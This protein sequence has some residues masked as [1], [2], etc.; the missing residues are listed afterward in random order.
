MMGSDSG[1]GPRFTELGPFLLLR[2]IGEGGMGAIH[3][4]VQR[5][6]TGLLRPCVVKL[7]RDPLLKDPAHQARIRH[8]AKTMMRLEHANIPR[9]V[10]VGEINGRWFVA[11]E[12]VEGQ[13]LAAVL[14]EMA[15]RDMERFSPLE[16]RFIVAEVLAALEYA[17]ALRDPV[18]DTPL[19]IVHRDISPQNILVGYD[20]RV[21]LIDF[22]ISVSKDRDFR[23][24]AGQVAGRAR[25]MAPERAQSY[26]V[27]ARADLFAVGQIYAECLSGEPFYGKKKMGEIIALLVDGQVEVPRSPAINQSAHEIIARAVRVEPEQRYR[28]AAEMLGEFRLDGVERGQAQKTLSERLARLFDVQR[29]REQRAALLLSAA[30]WLPGQSKPPEVPAVSIKAVPEAVDL[31]A[32]TRV[33]PLTDAAGD[34]VADPALDPTAASS[35]TSQQP[36]GLT[37]GR[38]VPA[39]VLLADIGAS[40]PFLSEAAARP[41]ELDEILRSG[42]SDAIVLGD[43]GDITRSI[44]IE[45]VFE[46]GVTLVRQIHL[47][48]DIDQD[49]ELT[50]VLARTDVDAG[51]HR[52][53]PF[54]LFVLQ[55]I[56][57]TKTVADI[58]AEMRLSENDLRLALALLVDKHLLR[59]VNR[60]APIDA[61][62]EESG[63]LPAAVRVQTPSLPHGE[64]AVTGAADPSSFARAVGPA[65]RT[66]S[67]TQPS[68]PVAPAPAAASTTASTAASIAAPTAPTASTASTASTAAPTT[69][70][71]TS[72]I[73]SPKTPPA[74]RAPS[75]PPSQPTI[76]PIAPSSAP[77]P[78]PHT[79]PGVHSSPSMPRPA[80]GSARALVV[81]NAQF[82][83]AAL[84]EQCLRDVKN[85]ALD[86]ARGLLEQAVSWMPDEPR[87]RAALEDWSAFVERNKT[88]ED[89]HALA[90]AI[91][92]EQ[93]G[94]L[95]NA[96][97]LLR[98]V[99]QLNPNNASAW[100]RLGL[101]LARQKDT[102][103]ALEALTQA[104]RA[105]PNDAAIRSNLLKVASAAQKGGFDLGLGDLWKRLTKT[106]GEGSR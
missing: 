45:I 27:D 8:E 30:G 101:L 69:S 86:K 50:T 105:A 54:E 49:I 57:G 12:F 31:E 106:D 98:H 20:G 60:E 9:V 61:Q 36:A 47:G 77:R 40:V 71:P 103:G 88:R 92:A 3:F 83:A 68:S 41:L 91:R 97:A 19:G 46:D 43:A 66:A 89:L 64:R 10:E 21:R 95:A 6:Q 100:N 63:E 96:T 65:Q 75:L 15:T 82:R 44:E 67:T 16:A 73:T 35:P 51:A 76:P 22:G 33:F 79:S 1:S 4:A 55:R 52:L 48:S 39:E 5:H 59:R 78:V 7:L 80:G 58:Q 13:S 87:Y 99:T 28:D 18:T 72:P 24:R 26:D 85:G 53:S 23:T 34:R 38:T 14:R 93:L 84:Y 56:T 11:L 17:H 29:D 104:L 74:A 32:T 90:L 102:R 94:N 42:Q 2:T 81:D 70:R 37:S 62:P 25:Y